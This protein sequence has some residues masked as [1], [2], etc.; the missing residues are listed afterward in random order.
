MK[1]TRIICGAIAIALMFAFA[2]GLAQSIFKR[3][4]SIAFIVIVAL[5]LIMVAVD[6]IQGIREDAANDD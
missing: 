1:A 2:G 4:E 3:T 6:A 5:V